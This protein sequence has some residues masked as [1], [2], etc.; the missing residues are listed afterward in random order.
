MVKYSGEICHHLCQLFNIHWTK[1]D[2]LTRL[3]LAKFIQD[4]GYKM[5][6]LDLFR[7]LILIFNNLKVKRVVK[8]EEGWEGTYCLSMP[9]TQRF[10]QNGIHGFNCQG[11]GIDTVIFATTSSDYVLLNK[12]LIYTALTRCR[13]KGIVVAESK[14]LRSACLKSS[15]S[16]KQTFLT[17]LLDQ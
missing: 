7:Y 17:Q 12:E 1:R 3:E 2:D 14:A 11:S 9:C 8:I 6:H 15:L 16:T 4:F 5:S 13:K 10:V